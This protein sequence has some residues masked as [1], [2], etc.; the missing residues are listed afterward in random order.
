MPEHE[1]LLF[2]SWEDFADSFQLY[3]KDG[4]HLNEKGLKV[5][6]RRMDKCLSL[7]QEN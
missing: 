1:L 4:V 5:F 3:K 7:W 2:R 6:A